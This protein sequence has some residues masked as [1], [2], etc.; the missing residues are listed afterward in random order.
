MLLSGLPFGSGSGPVFI[1]RLDCR[2]N[3]RRL[4]DCTDVNLRRETCTHDNDVSIQCT[5]NVF[6]IVEVRIIFHMKHDILFVDINECGVNNGN[7]SHICVNEI[8]FYHC[9]CPSDGQLDPTNRTCIFNAN[10]S[11]ENETFTCDC[12]SGYEDLDSDNLNCTGTFLY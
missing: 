2:G 12:L 6:N 4:L 1:E 3:E 11:M 8:P 9:D 5:G 7:C 10:C